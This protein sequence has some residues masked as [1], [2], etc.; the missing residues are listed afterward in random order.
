MDNFVSDDSYPDLLA[1]DWQ[2]DLQ[3]FVRLLHPD[4]PLTLSQLLSYLENLTK[5]LPP[6]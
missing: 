2:N 4:F 6:L 1:Q 3:I 5:L